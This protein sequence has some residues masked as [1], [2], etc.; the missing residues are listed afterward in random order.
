MFFGLRAEGC[1]FAEMCIR[2]RIRMISY[3]GIFTRL[4]APFLAVYVIVMFTTIGS[5][6]FGVVSTLSDL[7]KIC[8]LYT[9]IASIDSF[10]THNRAYAKQ[11]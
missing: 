7:F 5:L 4:E 3:H 6:L 9:S 11:A 8:L 10:A 2:D 1:L